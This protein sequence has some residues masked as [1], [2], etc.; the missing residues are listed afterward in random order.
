[1]AGGRAAVVVPG[2]FYSADG[3]LLMYAG[4]AVERRGGSVRRISWTVPHFGDDDDERAWVAARVSEAVDAVAAATSVA[5]P[6]VIGKSLGSLAASVAASRGLPAVWLTPVLTDEPTV[7]ALRRAAAPCLLIGGTADKVW[8]GRL[9]RSLTPHVLEID[10]ADH[11]MFVPGRLSASAAVLGQVTT[12][13]EN[14]LDH[15]V[16]PQGNEQGTS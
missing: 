7:A 1:M 4:L 8:D 6:V 15:Q 3:P 11:G 12:A 16:W 2:L 5:A 9:G 13:V 10:G 14:F